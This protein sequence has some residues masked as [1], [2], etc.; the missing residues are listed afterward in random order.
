MTR[1]LRHSRASSDS[2]SSSRGRRRTCP[3]SPPRPDTRFRSG[4]TT[5][6]RS[7]RL[8]SRM[9]G[10]AIGT[11]PFRR[12]EH[13]PDRAILQRN[14]KYWREPH[15]RLDRIEFRA[16]LPAAEIVD[17]LR[18]G[19][20][21]LVRDLLPQDL[22][23]IVRDVRF[24]GGLSETPKKNSYFA[25]FH[26]ASPAGSNPALRR[27]LAG[28]TR[29]QEFVWGALGRFAMPATGLIPPGVLAHDP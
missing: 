29:S 28:V 15:A 6:C 3:A 12:V 22:D 9:D 18:A 14:E 7:S 25:M 10:A 21:D 17:G 13:A 23:A 8:S 5:R 11:G 19:R 16:S 27:A 26:Q 24:R 4:S 20:L 2:P 1:C